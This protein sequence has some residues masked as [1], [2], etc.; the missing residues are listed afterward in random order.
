LTC[1]AG[2][3]IKKEVEN[4]CVPCGDNYKT[5]VDHLGITE[6]KDGFAPFIDSTTKQANCHACPNKYATKC[7]TKL[8]E[9]ACVSPLYVESITGYGECQICPEF[10]KCED[11]IGPVTCTKTEEYLYNRKCYTC[12]DRNAVKCKD[13]EGASECAGSDWL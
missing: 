5:C 9:Q 2:S 3:Y 7:D 4:I 13:N 8:G 10:Q 1:A 12:S 11:N 6:C